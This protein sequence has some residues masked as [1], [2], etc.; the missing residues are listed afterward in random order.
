MEAPGTTMGNVEGHG[1]PVGSRAGGPR[2]LVLA[3]MGGI[4]HRRLQEWGA[5]DP[6]DYRTD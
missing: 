5:W 3:G 1:V 6:K 2:G 4:K